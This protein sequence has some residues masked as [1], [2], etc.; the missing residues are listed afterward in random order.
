MVWRWKA[1][2]RKPMVR[3]P[4]MWWVGVGVVPLS[5]LRRA[6]GMITMLSLAW[7]ERYL[8]PMRL[9]PMWLFEWWLWELT[10]FLIVYIIITSNLSIDFMSGVLDL[11]NNSRNHTFQAV[12]FLNVL[13]EVL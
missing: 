9:L 7:M 5:M 11:L 10:K 4:V 3:F 12:A 8:W 6:A 2:D 1:T 13:L